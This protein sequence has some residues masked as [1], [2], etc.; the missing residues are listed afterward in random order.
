MMTIIIISTSLGYISLV[1]LGKEAMKQA[2]GGKT[3]GVCWAQESAQAAH[4]GS[5]EKEFR[6]YRDQLAFS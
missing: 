2:T 5:E 3:M 1:V 4:A 6:Y